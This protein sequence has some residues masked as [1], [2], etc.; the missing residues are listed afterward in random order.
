MVEHKMVYGIAGESVSDIPG[1]KSAGM[2]DF[3][4]VIHGGAAPT[5]NSWFV[6]QCNNNNVSPIMNNGNDG[7]SGCVGYDPN[8]YYKT[9]AS[10]GWHAAGGESEP[11]VE[12]NAIMANLVGMDYGGEWNCCTD[13]SN[14]WAHQMKGQKVSGKGMCAYL[15][16]YVGVCGVYL[17]P[18]AV[19]KAAKA[20]KDAGCKEVGIMIGGWMIN[21]GYGAQY[22][23]DL[24][25]R[26]EKEAGVTVA[27]VVLWWGY[28]QNMN[29]IYSVNASIIKALQAIWPPDMRTLK[30]RFGATNVVPTTET[31]FASKVT[32]LPNEKVTITGTLKDSAGKGIAGKPL[33]IWHYLNNVRYDDIKGTTNAS[34][35]LS[36][37]QT[38]SAE[39]VRPY[40]STFAGDTTYGASTSPVLNINVINPI[41]Q[42]SGGAVCTS[43]DT[44][45]LFVEGTDNALYLKKYINGVWS[46]AWERL[47][48]TLTSTPSASVMADGSIIVAARGNDK[49]LWYRILKDGT[50]GDWKSL[51]GIM[52]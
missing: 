38:F 45:Y 34:G 3:H 15:E 39:G 24:I 14:I 27:G 20:C 2:I 41:A 40:Y 31:L 5:T 28:G 36:I 44:T 16:T 46:G 37:D 33:T 42:G 48:G 13:L 25:R 19:V 4:M 8:T 22:Y 7:V 26:I 1:L 29:S 17:C 51:G 6:A 30:T 52:Y 43:G 49:A 32:C 10:L 35:Q 11:A 18:D 50:W 21:H 12:W 23:I 9:V 47:G